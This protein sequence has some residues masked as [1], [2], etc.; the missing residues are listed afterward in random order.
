MT[1]RT[2]GDLVLDIS[3]YVFLIA[4]G[5]IMLLPLLNVLSKSVSEEWAI[6]SGKVG[7]LPVGFQLDTL[8]EVIS[9]DVH[10][11]LLCIHWCHCSRNGYF[12]PD[13]RTYRVPVIQ[14]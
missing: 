3:V 6:T 13:D 8:K 10:T 2:K 9:S 4:L 11:R 12:D 14:T 1:K 7:I 5:I